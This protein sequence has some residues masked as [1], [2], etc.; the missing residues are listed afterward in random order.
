[1][2]IKYHKQA[3]KFL[4]KQESKISAR[5]ISV[6]NKLPVGDVRKMEGYKDRYRLRVGSYRVIFSTDFIIDKE[7]KQQ[8]RVVKVWDIDDRGDIY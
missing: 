1:M 5:I 3:E 6:I 2:Q 8:V 7:T 4:F